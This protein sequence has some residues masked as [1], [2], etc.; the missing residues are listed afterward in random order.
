MLKIPKRLRYWN[1]A[2]FKALERIETVAKKNGLTLA[3][4]LLL[5]RIN[6]QS[7]STDHLSGCLAMDDEP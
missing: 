2:Y 6:C 7:L 1:D 3:E 5:M 4:V